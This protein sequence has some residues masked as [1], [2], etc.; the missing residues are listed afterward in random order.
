MAAW[1]IATTWIAGV[2]AERIPISASLRDS[3]RW[4]FGA[5]RHS[6]TAMVSATRLPHEKFKKRRPRS[7]YLEFLPYILDPHGPGSRLASGVI[8][9]LRRRVHRNAP[10]A[11][12]IRRLTWPST[13]QVVALTRWVRTPLSPCSTPPAGRACF[14]KPPL[15]NYGAA[16]QALMSF[17]L[18]L[19]ACLAPTSILGL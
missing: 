4:F 6:L 2:A 10:K 3:E 1:F 19:N 11:F 8:H 7:R 18:H 17:R 14:S 16:F 13:W 5:S 15:P 12:S 9:R